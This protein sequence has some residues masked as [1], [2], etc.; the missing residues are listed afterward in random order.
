MSQQGCP[1]IR[2]GG[3]YGAMR[4]PKRLPWPSEQVKLKR[5]D[6]I[7]STVVDCAFDTECR[8]QATRHIHQAADRTPYERNP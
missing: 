4:L 7:S 1:N 8:K 2:R 3:D 6:E 5:V